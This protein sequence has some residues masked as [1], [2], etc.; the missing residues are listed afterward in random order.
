MRL[1]PASASRRLQSRAFQRGLL[2]GSRLWFAVFLGGAVRR[3]LSKSLSAKEMPVALSERLHP[4]E[5]MVI[6]HIPPP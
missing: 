6:R 3:W 2:G 5:G 4:G 1:L